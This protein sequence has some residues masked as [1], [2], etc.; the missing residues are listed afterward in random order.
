MPDVLIWCA[1]AV[2]G[3][4]AARSTWSPCGLSMLS[5]IT[6][7]A[8]RSR[9]HRYSWTAAWFIAGAVVGGA[10]LGAVAA[11]LAAGV[12]ATGA[13]AHP[14]AIAAV[15]AGLAL[16]GAAVDAGVLGGVLPLVRRQVDDGWL[17]AYRP[18]LYGAGFGWQLGVGLATYLMTAGVVV[19]TVLAALTGSPAAAVLVGIGFGAARGV[20]VLLT[21]RCHTPVQLRDLHR[22]L[23]RSRKAVQAAAAAAQ[24]AVAVTLV[25]VVAG[26]LDRSRLPGGAALV[27]A[28][29]VPPLVVAVVLAPPAARAGARQSPANAGAGPS[30]AAAG[31]GRQRALTDAER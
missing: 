1:L 25:W 8:E 11:L 13:T 19:L 28:V 9:G 4:A 14:V 23:D 27:A 18:W 26:G 29:A 5:S 7:F 22:R 2:A 6:P 16:T 31:P 12:A 10:C 3:L 21:A 17:A 15:G 24:A 20:T 30:A